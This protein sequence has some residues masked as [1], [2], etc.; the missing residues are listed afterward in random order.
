MTRYRKGADAERELIHMLYD[1]G[2]SVVRAAG[3]GATALPAPDLIAMRAGRCIAFESKAWDAAYLNIP[4]DQ[5]N[6]LKGWCSRAGAELV[7]AWKIPRA[8]WL[9]LKAEDFVD[10]GKNHAITRKNAES[11]A[12]N[13]SVLAGHQSRLD[14]TKPLKAAK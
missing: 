14:L 4:N 5:M 12:I 10:T 6:E 11:R 2:F 1:L 3:S 9:F 8:G 13:I 7:V